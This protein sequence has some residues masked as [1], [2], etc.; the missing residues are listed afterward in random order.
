SSPAPGSSSPSPL[1]TSSGMAS[2]T[3][4]TRGSARVRMMTPLLEIE[5]LAVQVRSRRAS[6]LA[7]DGVHL[8]IAPGEAV[9]FVAE[10][11]CGKS[12]TALSVLR[13]VQPPAVSIVRGRISFEGRD[14]LALSDAAIQDLRGSDVAMIFQDP[15]TFMNPVFNV[16]RQI[17]EAIR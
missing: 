14:L 4:S 2:A 16:E 13:L 9:A 3:F 15:M 12:L 10:S 1:S 17:G 7:V 6:M 8:R 5:D 11:G